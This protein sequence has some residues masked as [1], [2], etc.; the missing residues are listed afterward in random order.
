MTVG[1]FDYIS[2]PS[3][4]PKP[5]SLLPLTRRFTA[6]SKWHCLYPAHDTPRAT[7]YFHWVCAAEATSDKSIPVSVDRK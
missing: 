5:P 2:T 3:G 6:N 4:S 1:D 7:V